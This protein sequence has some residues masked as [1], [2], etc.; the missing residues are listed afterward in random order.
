MPVT[1]LNLPYPNASDPIA[2]Y[3]AQASSM[4]WTL[5]TLISRLAP[6]NAPVHLGTRPS[7]AMVPQ[8]QI[9]KQRV[10]L[11]PSGLVQVRPPQTHDITGL[12]FA[13]VTCAEINPR[14]LGISFSV[15]ETSGDW[16]AST[17]SFTIHSQTSFGGLTNLPLLIFAIFARSS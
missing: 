16:N 1:T 5:D 2:D 11:N 15:G 8:V 4:A 14:S 9:W 7:A 13:A 17:K 12:I 10:N 3:P 6:L